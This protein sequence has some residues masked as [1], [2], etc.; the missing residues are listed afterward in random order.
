MWV[1]EDLFRTIARENLL[2]KKISLWMFYNNYYNINY[3]I[4]NVL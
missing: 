2:E 1:K 4:L 3:Y